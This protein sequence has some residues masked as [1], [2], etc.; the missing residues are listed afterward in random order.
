MDELLYEYA[1][2][3]PGAARDFYRVAYWRWV[4]YP[5]DFN[6]KFSRSADQLWVHWIDEEL[7]A[8]TL[9]AKE[10]GEKF[11]PQVQVFDQYRIP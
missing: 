10:N 4:R 11:P 8:Q 7:K 2:F 1:A 6:L 5:D 9:E 3:V